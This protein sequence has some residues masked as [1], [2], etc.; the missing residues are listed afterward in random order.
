M[1]YDFMPKI[2]KIKRSESENEEE[3]EEVHLWK[4][5]PENILIKIFKLLTAREILNSSEVCKRWNC[6]SRDSLL[7][8]AKFH[9]DFKADKQIKLKPSKFKFNDLQ[10]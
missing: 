3:E 9:Q 5:L 6:V 10:N 1:S 2:P 7:W 8:K 4:N